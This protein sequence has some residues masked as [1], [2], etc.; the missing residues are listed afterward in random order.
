MAL[1]KQ[2][3]TAEISHLS[4]NYMDSGI[5]AYSRVTSPFLL[6]LSNF[7]I[8]YQLPLILNSISPRGSDTVNCTSQLIKF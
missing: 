5:N 2:K 3:T 1:D 6:F 8:S 7:C 4:Q